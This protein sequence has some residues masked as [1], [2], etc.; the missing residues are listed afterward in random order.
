MPRILAWLIRPLVE[1]AN[2]QIHVPSGC[3]DGP[4][5]A[6]DSPFSWRIL[7][8][9]EEPLRRGAVVVLGERR[10]WAVAHARR[11]GC[12]QLAVAGV[13]ARGDEDGGRSRPAGVPAL[14]STSVNDSCSTQKPCAV[15]RAPAMW[16]AV[17]AI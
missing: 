17:T 6:G 14:C 7:P 13:C 12:V 5:S 8:A 3:A 4:P 16:S 10:G 2:R 9:L 15:C 11:R 1:E